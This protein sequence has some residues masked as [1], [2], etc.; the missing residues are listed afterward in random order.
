MASGEVAEGG[1]DAGRIMR[2]KATL[3]KSM[4]ALDEVGG[5]GG[6]VFICR[7]QS[8][9][10]QILRSYRMGVFH[11]RCWPQER[12]RGYARIMAVHIRHCI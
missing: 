4:E 7:R 10:Y 8:S 11:I 9:K 2:C 12:Y 6:W 5:G 3:Q 1:E